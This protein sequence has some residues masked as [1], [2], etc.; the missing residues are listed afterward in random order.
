[1]QIVLNMRNKFKI[2]KCV[3]IHILYMIYDDLFTTDQV[4]LRPNLFSGMYPNASRK[5]N[6]YT[7]QYPYNLYQPL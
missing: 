3:P 7:P 1:M 6:Y 4:W 5:Q 2:D